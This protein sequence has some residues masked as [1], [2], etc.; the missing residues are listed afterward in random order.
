MLN[1]P[2]IPDLTEVKT[3]VDRIDDNVAALRV[4][5]DALTDKV[6]DIHVVFS[7]LGPIIAGMPP[8]GGP[9]SPFEPS[10]LITV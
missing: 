3:Q 2:G 10:G 4:A 6:N 5:L 1:L 9:V 8:M 7:A